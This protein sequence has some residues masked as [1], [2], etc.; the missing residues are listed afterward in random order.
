MNAR[1]F[2]SRW[3][4]EKDNLLASFVE[5]T[6]TLRVADRIRAMNLTDEQREKLE[7]VIDSV[8][9][10]TFYTLL[11]GLDG[12][13]QIGGVQETYEIRGEDGEVISEC[14]DI[15][16]VAGEFFLA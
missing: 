10:D 8:L 11:L 3:R 7:G 6:S 9:V 16:G 14:G 15:E 5:P 2:V 4:K 1:E 12:C 13:T